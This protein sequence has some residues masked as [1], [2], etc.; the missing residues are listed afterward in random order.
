MGFVA[1]VLGS[2]AELAKA[3]LD[4]VNLSN[5]HSFSLAMQGRGCGIIRGL[6]PALVGNQGTLSKENTNEAG[7]SSRIC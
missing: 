1:V 6:C 5:L 3:R 7:N 4:S 2:N